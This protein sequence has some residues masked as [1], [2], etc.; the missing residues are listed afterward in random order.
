MPKEFYSRVGRLNKGGGYRLA[1]LTEQEEFDLII[2]D[3][4]S[5]ALD[6]D[7]NDNYEVERALRPILE[8]IHKYG[9]AVLL[10]DHHRKGGKAFKDPNVVLDVL[11]AVSKTA[12]AD[13]IWGIWKPPDVAHR[14][15]HVIGRD[16]GEDYSFD[17][18]LDQA[19]LR[20]SLGISKSPD[21]IRA[22]RQR[23]A[24]NTLLKLSGDDGWVST[25][26]IVDHIKTTRPDDTPVNHGNVHQSLMALVAKRMVKTRQEGGLS[27]WTVGDNDWFCRGQNDFKIG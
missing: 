6:C 21:D 5:K 7:P 13:T 17:A 10:I 9:V 14:V 27:F 22:I 24:L 8:I 23:E 4:F 16:T 11:G 1:E 20:W 19:N 2:I 18:T 3:T 12:N 25:S 15:F 26:E